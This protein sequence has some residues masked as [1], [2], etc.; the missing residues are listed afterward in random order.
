MEKLKRSDCLQPREK[1]FVHQMVFNGLSAEQAC[2]H[3]CAEELTKENR[4]KIL[5]RAN[6]MFTRPRVYEYFQ[7]CLAEVRQEEKGKAVWTREIATEKLMRLIEAAERDLYGD[8]ENGVPA[9]KMTM[10]RINGVVLPAKELNLMNGFNNSNVNVNGGVTV[11]FV[12]E[13]ELED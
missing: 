1:D 8:P 5:A 12:G 13:D 4:S 11:K 2:A 6:A 9:Q 7:E 3:A 10:S